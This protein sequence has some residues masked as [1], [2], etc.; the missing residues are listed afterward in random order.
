VQDFLKI[1][2]NIY[3][4]FYPSPPKLPVIVNS[5]LVSA[6]SNDFEVL[7]INIASIILISTTI[8]VKDVQCLYPNI[9]KPK[10]PC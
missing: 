10:I 8:P 1:P 4:V 9:I 5:I 3:S 7:R 6:L 2:N